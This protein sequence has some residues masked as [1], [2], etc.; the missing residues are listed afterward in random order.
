MTNNLKELHYAQWLETTLKEM[1]DFPVKGI[2]INAIS[3][4]GAVYTNYY[5]TSMNDKLLVAG[6]LQQDAMLDTLTMNGFINKEDE[7]E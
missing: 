1:L 2:C 3:A 4:D 6:L 7:T 5:K